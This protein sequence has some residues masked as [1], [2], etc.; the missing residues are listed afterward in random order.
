[1]CG[2]AVVALIG[3]GSSSPTLSA[4]GPAS[5]ETR[6]AEDQA[7]RQVCSARDNIET[8]VQTLASLSAGGA[9]KAEVTSALSA[10]TADLQKVKDAEPDLAPDRRQDVQDAATAFGAQLR[11]TVRQTAAGVLKTNPGTQ[12]KNAAASL[13]SAANES[14]QAIQC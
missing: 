2:C 7:A 9:T 10:I 4:T 3:C 14:L 1:V 11:D 13:K 8:Q 5:G 6:S 12:A